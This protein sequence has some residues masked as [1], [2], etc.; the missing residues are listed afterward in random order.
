[1][2]ANL[3]TAPS[4]V[5]ELDPEALLLIVVGAHWRAEVSHRP[6]AYRLCETIRNRLKQTN[7]SR[8]AGDLSPIVCS[9][10]WYLND[11]Q[12]AQRPI[13]ALGDPALNAATAYLS[14]R[15]PTAFV[16]EQTLRV[17]LDPDFIEAQ[18]CIW[19]ADE[20]A[21]VAG[22]DVFVERY[23]DEFLREAV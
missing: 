8:A 21:T 11:Q 23:L 16:L 5:H 12:L 7:G 20:S 22:I 6:L 19:G 14:T 2:D 18:A 3:V 4:A 1:M 17:H 15:L 9:D 10:L 13:I